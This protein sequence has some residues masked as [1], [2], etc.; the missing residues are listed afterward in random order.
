MINKNGI[1]AKSDLR[2]GSEGLSD[3]LKGGFWA[4]FNAENIAR[5]EPI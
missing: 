4:V 1:N 2:S 5:W 3:E